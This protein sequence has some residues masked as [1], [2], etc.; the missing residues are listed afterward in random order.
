MKRIFLIFTLG[1]KNLGLPLESVERVTFASEITTLPQSPKIVLGL[2]NLQNE[3][4]PVLN[5]R[6]FFGAPPR[7]IKL[8]DQFIITKALSRKVALWVESTGEVSEFNLQEVLTP[9]DLLPGIDYLDGVIK[10]PDGLM[11]IPN[12]NQF[13]SH[14]E[15]FLSQILKESTPPGTEGE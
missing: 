11:L 5:L 8:E 4:I 2:I 7:R 1:D 3:V 6:K 9:K 15:E 10:L 14:Q 12:L 13:L